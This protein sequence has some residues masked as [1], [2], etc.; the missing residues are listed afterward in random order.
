[1]A[2]TRRNP[3]GPPA[4][5]GGGAGPPAGGGA[6]GGA[7]P[8]AGGGGGAGPPAGGG[9]V[10]D[11]VLTAEEQAVAA[12]LAQVDAA[13]AANKNNYYT[14]RTLLVTT[15]ASRLHKETDR[16]LLPTGAVFLDQTALAR[17]DPKGIEASISAHNRQNKGFGQ[18]I[19][20]GHGSVLHGLTHVFR[21]ER[22]GRDLWMERAC[23]PSHPPLPP[24]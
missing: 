21:L 9:S 6:G 7:G 16:Y 14:M 15:G 1:M 8:P 5:G 19:T 2:G 4:D 12:S 13:P 24:R 22:S 20:P 3:G 17:S 18:G 10:G 11:A 23:K